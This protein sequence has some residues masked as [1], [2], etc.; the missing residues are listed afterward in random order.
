MAKLALLFPGQGSQVV[1]MGKDFFDNFRESRLVF[2]EVSDI[3][4]LD[5]KSLCF[6]G[7]MEALTLTPNLQPALFA[8]EAAMLA[9]MYAHSELRPLVTAG[10]S[11]GEYS[12]LHAAGSLSIA[13]GARLTRA[14]GTAMQKAVPPGHGAMAA[15]LGLE[16]ELIEKLCEKAQAGAHG[17]VIEPANFNTPGQVVVA[18]TV[19]GIARATALLKED[20]QFKGGKSIALAVS[21]PFHCSLMDPAQ[22]EMA[23]LLAETTYARPRCMV[24]P[25][26]TAQPTDN[27]IYFSGLLTDQITRP[28]LWEQSMRGLRS[29][30][31]D[32][33]VELGPGKVL[34][35]MLKRIDR[36][37]QVKSVST[38]EQLKEAFK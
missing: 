29:L 16:N 22:K 17:E 11:L 30:G 5:L 4:H 34:T 31:V 24:I 15:I 37:L 26:V 9:A 20:E 35:G 3:I 33:V 19:D 14:R 13:D 1:G 25:N 2:E 28:V 8:T 32:T 36:E 6:D 18:G 27:E 12:A 38:V 10:H 21:A 23:P 7:P